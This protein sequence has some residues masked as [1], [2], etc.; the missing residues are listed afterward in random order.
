[1]NTSTL[2][3]LCDRVGGTIQTGPFGSQ[4]HQSDYRDEGVAVVMPQDIVGNR[5]STER[6]AHIDE[7]LAQKFERHL[8]SSGDIVFPRRGEIS[9]RALIGDHGGPFFCGTGCLKISMPPAEVLPKWLFYYLGQAHVVAWIE[10]KAVGST[11]L[12]LNT[13]IMRSVPVVYPALKDQGRI[14]YFLDA[15]DD[16]IANNQRRI[17]LLEQSARLLYREWFV[18]LRFPGHESVPVSNGVPDG[19]VPSVFSDLVTVNPRTAFDKDRA[20]P[21]VDMGALSE[22]SMV[23][24]ER[25]YRVIGGGAKFKNGD[26]LFA[27]ITPCIQNGKTGFV[28]FLDET[29]PVASGSTEFIVFRSAKVNPWWVYC[30]SREDDFRQH[31]IN[32]MAGSDGRQRVNP[33]CFDQYEVLQPPPAVLDQ[34]EAAVKDSFA[35]VEV[36]CSANKQ[37]ARARDLLLPKLMSGQLD[38]SSIPL[39]EAKYVAA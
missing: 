13:G 20:Y 25:S 17:A 9:K 29:E 38:V 6:I 5:V 39:P 11:M 18:Q 26:T 3:Q 36:L 37:L 19:W 35:Q 33:K 15:Y 1:M 14:V 28:Q 10:S 30:L 34:F 24:G 4:I 23:I 31:A 8:L 22:S 7:A 12:N 32:S 21:F 2:G 27:R 16:L